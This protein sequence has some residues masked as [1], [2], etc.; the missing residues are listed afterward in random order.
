MK[1]PTGQRK[2]LPKSDFATA[3]GIKPT[4]P[5]KAAPKAPKEPTHPQS[6][7]EFIKLGS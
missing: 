6:H 1:L 2:A 7:S 4:A 5:M 3:K